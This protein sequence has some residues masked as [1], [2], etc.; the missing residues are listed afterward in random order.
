MK[1]KRKWK[2]SGGGGA[3]FVAFF[4]VPLVV[5]L[6]FILLVRPTYVFADATGLVCVLLLGAFTWFISL[7]PLIQ[8]RW[9]L[10]ARSWYEASFV[11]AALYVFYG[12]WIFV[13]GYTPVRFN[14]H[15]IPRDYGFNWLAIACFPFLIGIIA[16]LYEKKN[17]S[18]PLK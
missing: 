7:R 18:E 6:I 12:V 17:T 15:I 3:L 8:E 2:F 1:K 13:T 11:L 10:L 14:S 9:W 5:R 16:Y 4:F